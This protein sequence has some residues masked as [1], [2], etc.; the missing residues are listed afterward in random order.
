MEIFKISFALFQ[1]HFSKIQPS[2]GEILRFQ[3]LF[4]PE[5]LENLGNFNV[6]IIIIVILKQS[7]SNLIKISWLPT[8][9]FCTPKQQGTFIKHIYRRWKIHNTPWDILKHI[10]KI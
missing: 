6:L 2:D 3:G 1:T 7:N 10:L 8:W 9:Y 5:I 4:H